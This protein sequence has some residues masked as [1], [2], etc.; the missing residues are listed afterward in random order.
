MLLEEKECRNHDFS[1][2]TPPPIQ[3]PWSR[4]TESLE[5]NPTQS[6]PTDELDTEISEA[7]AQ[8]ANLIRQ[9]RLIELQ[10]QV[11]DEQVA[12]EVARKRL[13]ATSSKDSSPTVSTAVNDSVN[14]QDKV[15]I[16]PMRNGYSKAGIIQ[17]PNTALIAPS[18]QTVSPD[19]RTPQSNP[20]S[21]EL[22][23]TALS[24][25]TNPKLKI[26]GEPATAKESAPANSN[27]QTLPAPNIPVYH[28][29]ALGEFKNYARCLEHH[30]DRYSSWYITDE[31]KVTRT[32]KHVAFDLQNEWKR[33]I[34]NKPPEQLQIGVSPEVARARYVDSYQRPFQSVTDFSNWIQQWEPHFHN[35]L[36]ERDRM[37]HLFEHLSNKVREEADK[38]YLDF[39]HYYD[40]V[41]YLQRIEDSI[42]KRAGP[43]RKKFSN[44]RK[45][46][47]TGS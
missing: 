20:S 35:D 26:S 28:G 18:E 14:R 5:P 16:T 38:T 36:S 15:L 34:R 21:V 1:V 41:V 27:N 19:L 25:P 13:A 44:P 2:E 43:L 23:N 46:H 4:Q 37:R 11:S 32:L 31:R 12:L 45:R 7:Q 39:T 24:G 9:R 10:Q 17:T 30:F 8:L 42:D 22:E 47:H 29:R 40:F 33:Q 3:A 6:Q